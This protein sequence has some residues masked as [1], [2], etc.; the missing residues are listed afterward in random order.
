M[1]VSGKETKLWSS[2]QDASPSAGKN[3]GVV[4]AP[5]SV[6][7]CVPTAISKVPG[8][9]LLWQMSSQWDSQ[10]LPQRLVSYELTAYLSVF[11]LFLTQ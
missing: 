5:F 6:W 10:Q 11:D 7:N 9:H 3:T 4:Y 8:C 1:I 2:Y